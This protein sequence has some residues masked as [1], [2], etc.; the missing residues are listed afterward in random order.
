[1]NFK[2][3]YLRERRG[4]SVRQMYERL[5][6]KDSRYRKWES[7]AAAMPLEYAVEAC[8]ILRCSLDEL[9]GLVVPAPSDDEQR[10][11]DLYRST[12]DR[13]RL[14]IMSV[15]ES[16]QGVEGPSAADSKIVHR[17]CAWIL[18]RLSCMS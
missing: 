18:S 17:F 11:L 1:M 14:V 6:V 2:L 9:L 8:E 4:L 13:G 7:E 12:D 16:Q 5:G 15:A 3:R 10:L